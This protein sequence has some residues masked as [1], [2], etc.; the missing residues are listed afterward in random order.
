MAK[1]MAGRRGYSKRSG[2]RESEPSVL[3]AA[4]EGPGVIG[5]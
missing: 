5:R 1:M 4:S 3:A 2:K